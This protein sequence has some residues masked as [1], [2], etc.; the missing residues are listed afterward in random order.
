MGDIIQG[1]S[2]PPN[3]KFFWMNNGRLYV[4]CQDRI[5]YPLEDQVRP[6][7]FDEDDENQAEAD[8]RVLY[9]VWLIQSVGYRAWMDEAKRIEA[10]HVKT[11]EGFADAL[12][13]QAN[14]E[15]CRGWMPTPGPK[16]ASPSSDATHSRG[17]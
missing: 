8:A 10:K 15:T 11:G 6:T 16:H 12:R 1:F 5:Y 3:C 17:T 14:A 13:A 9:W 2:V 7:P 4:K